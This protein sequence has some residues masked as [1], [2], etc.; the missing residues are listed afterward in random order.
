MLEDPSLKTLQPSLRLKAIEEFNRGEFTE[1]H[2]SL[3]ML[4]KAEQRPIRQFYQGL[5]QIGAAFHHLREQ[6][7]PPVMMLLERGSRYLEPFA[8]ICMGVDLSELMT[9]SVWCLAEV[10]RLGPGRLNEFDWSLVPTV[11][12][13]SD[14][15]SRCL[16]E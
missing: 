3:E 4:W 14:S 16:D 5:L 12:T 10:Q 9:G 2:D 11:E 15:E 6:H 1:C 13:K 7:C 8:P